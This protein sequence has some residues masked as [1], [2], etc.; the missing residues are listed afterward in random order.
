MLATPDRSGCRPDSTRF[1]VLPGPLAEDGVHSLL[2]MLDLYRRVVLHC[3]CDIAVAED[4]HGDGRGDVGQ[5]EVGR[6]RAARGVEV[7]P[8][9]LAIFGLEEV[10]TWAGGWQ[11]CCDRGECEG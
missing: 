1:G 2:F 3:C 10:D 7:H 9:F 6:R 8:P 11:L 4:R 5:H